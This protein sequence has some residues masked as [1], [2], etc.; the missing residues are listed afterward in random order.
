MNSTSTKEAKEKV[1]KLRDSFSNTTQLLAGC[2]S[3]RAFYS[4]CAMLMLGGEPVCDWF[5]HLDKGVRID[6]FAR[7]W[8]INMAVG[9]GSELNGV[10]HRLMSPHQ[11]LPYLRAL[12][13][14]VDVDDLPLNAW[15]GAG[16]TEFVAEQ[17]ALMQRLWKHLWEVVQQITLHFAYTFLSY[18]G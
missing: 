13:L 8:Y 18:P 7:E 10:V 16:N 5:V 1:Q 15:T 11:R 4:D 14:A 3:D 6:G 17:Q 12:G 9:S 2:L